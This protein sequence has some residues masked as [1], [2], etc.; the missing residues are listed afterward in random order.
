MTLSQSYITANKHTLLLVAL[1][2]SVVL[3]CLSTVF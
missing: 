1:Y 3:F 2:Y